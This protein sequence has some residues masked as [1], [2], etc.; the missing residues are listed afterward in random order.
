MRAIAAIPPTTPPTI[1]PTFVLFF[2]L[3]VWLALSDDDDV[4]ELEEVFELLGEL[5]VTVT[6]PSLLALLVVASVEVGSDEVGDFDVEVWVFEVD[7]DEEDIAEV[8]EVAEV[9]AW[10]LAPEF[11]PPP[12][13]P[14]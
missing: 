5:L 1:G 10:E 11:A 14:V 3:A 8:A 4:D 12:P 2:E 13:G 6:K 9:E 7:S